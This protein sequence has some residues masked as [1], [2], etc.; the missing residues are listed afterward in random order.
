[1]IL[2][3]VNKLDRLIATEELEKL[4]WN[5]L[6]IEFSKNDRIGRIFHSNNHYLNL[7][8]RKNMMF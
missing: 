2:V 7:L 4:D 1:M 6:D 3:T 5:C 8:S